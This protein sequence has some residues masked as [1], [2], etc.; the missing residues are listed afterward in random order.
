MSTQAK[1][2]SPEV[3]KLSCIPETQQSQQ[4]DGWRS[5]WWEWRILWRCWI[6]NRVILRLRHSRIRIQVMRTLL[7]HRTHR[8]HR[9]LGAQNG[10]GKCKCKSKTKEGQDITEERAVNRSKKPAALFTA[11]EEQKLVDFLYDNE[12]L[13]NKALMDYKDRSKREA[14]WD[15]FCT[16]NNMDKDDCQRW[17]QSQ[18]TL[19]GKVTHMKSG[20]GEPQL[21]ERQKWIRGNFPFLRDHIVHHLTAKSEFRVPRGSAS[22]V[23]AAAAHHPDA[24]PCMWNRH[25]IL[26]IQ[27]PLMTHQTHAT[28]IHIPLLLD[29][30]ASV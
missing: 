5:W 15:K 7:T 18:H 11:E 22:Q 28:W 19:F 27:N 14:V 12:I 10:K 29:H 13:Y 6:Q 1:T 30:V 26:L 24:R 8:L 9:L 2:R 23:S 20:Q 4:A 16:E 25:R 17:F 21:A 3:D